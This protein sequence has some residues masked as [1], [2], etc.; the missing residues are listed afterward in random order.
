MHHV[1]SVTCNVTVL[2]MVF[3]ECIKQT[4]TK[5]NALTDARGEACGTPDKPASQG[6]VY[7]DVC[8]H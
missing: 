8:T 5:R 4:R 7:T 1:P 6:I 2:L 3:T